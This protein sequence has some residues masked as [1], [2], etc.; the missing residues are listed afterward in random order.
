VA[1]VCEAGYDIELRPAP[2]W[3]GVPDDIARYGR[4]LAEDL[5][6]RAEPVAVLVGLSVGTQAAAVAAAATPL[7]QR[8]VLVSPT[9][10]P[11]QRTMI[12]SIR[13]WIQGDP[14]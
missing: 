12:N 3:H 7:V 10:D 11:T 8:L 5:Q 6:R 9:I 14:P 13:A 2:A 4:E 1:E